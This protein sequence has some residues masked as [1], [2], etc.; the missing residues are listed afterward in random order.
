M[1]VLIKEQG[2]GFW[3]NGP[4][5]MSHWFSW[6]NVHKLVNQKSRK[7][8]SRKKLSLF[9]SMVSTSAI[10]VLRKF[11]NLVTVFP[12]LELQGALFG[13]GALFFK[14]H[15]EGAQFEKDSI[16]KGFNRENT[17]FSSPANHSLFPDPFCCYP[18]SGLPIFFVFQCDY[19]SCLCWN[20]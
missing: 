2:F 20:D 18:Q 17:V 6:K 19:R 4:L 1:S 10:K 15:L 3:K 8:A 16:W 5:F 13:G 12:R 9:T 14:R 11:S 7:S